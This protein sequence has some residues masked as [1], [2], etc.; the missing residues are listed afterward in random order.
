MRPGAHCPRQACALPSLSIPASTFLEAVPNS[1]CVQA[2]RDGISAGG[3]E[4]S[5]A[6]LIGQPGGTATD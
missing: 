4:S 5:A 3:T 2:G 6:V 1:M